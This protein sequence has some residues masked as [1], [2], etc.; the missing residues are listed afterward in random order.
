MGAYYGTFSNAI[1]CIDEWLGYKD[2]DQIT[3]SFQLDEL[4][5]CD[6]SPESIERFRAMNE[7]RPF[8][9][10]QD[11]NDENYPRVFRPLEVLRLRFDEN[12][13]PFV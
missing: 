9:Q 13:V 7:Y 5:L 2:W 6:Y 1:Q 11:D 3:L 10:L 8:Y 12:E 4:Y